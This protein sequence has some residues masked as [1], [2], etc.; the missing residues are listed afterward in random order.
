M[1]A[2]T[3]EVDRSRFSG[4]QARRFLVHRV[5]ECNRV[6]GRCGLG[7]SCTP[8]GEHRSGT[9]SSSDLLAGELPGRMRMY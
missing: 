4:V 1:E 3:N 6:A 7:S 2:K 8:W 5:A 9:R